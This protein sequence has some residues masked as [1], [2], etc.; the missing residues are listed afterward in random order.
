M[1]EGESGCHR[2]P[3]ERAEHARDCAATVSDA[4]M[5][6]ATAICRTRRRFIPSEAHRTAESSPARD[7][8]VPGQDADRAMAHEISYGDDAATD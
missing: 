7:V 2:R 6:A 4:A 5:S 1:S 8:P 3:F